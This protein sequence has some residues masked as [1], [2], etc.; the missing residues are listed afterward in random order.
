MSLVGEEPGVGFHRGLADDT[1]AGLEVGPY[2]EVRHLAV[3]GRCFSVSV[4]LVEGE[5]ERVRLVPQDVEP[6]TASALVLHRPFRVNLW[7]TAMKREFDLMG[8]RYAPITRRKSSSRS[9]LIS[10]FTTIARGAGISEGRKVDIRRELSLGRTGRWRALAWWSRER[11][12]GMQ[13][14]HQNMHRENK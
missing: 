3:S 2:L 9:S 11:T 8:Y 5:L 6:Q 14:A 13:R 10:T 1:S 4:H 7:E 12:R